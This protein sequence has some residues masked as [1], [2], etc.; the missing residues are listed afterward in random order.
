MLRSALVRGN[1][2]KGDACF[3]REG[4]LALGF[5]RRFLETLKRHPVFPEIDAGLFLKSLD[6]PVDDALVEILPAQIGVARGGENFEQS[7]F[8]LED[9]DIECAAAEVVDGD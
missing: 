1:E 9:G 6:H 7:L 4:E 2:G 8:E 3:L 5:L